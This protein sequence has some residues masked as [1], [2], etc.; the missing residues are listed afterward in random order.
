MHILHPYPGV[1][2][3]VGVMLTTN[4]IACLPL[5]PNCI[6]CLSNYVLFVG[7]GQRKWNQD[8]HSEHGGCSQIAQSSTLL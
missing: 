4:Y 2:V 7:G 5:L 6:T 8:S 1:V 3:C